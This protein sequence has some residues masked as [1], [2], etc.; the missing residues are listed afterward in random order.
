VLRHV[1]A[2]LAPQPGTILFERATVS[3]RGLPPQLFELWQQTD[4]PYRYR[5]IKWGHEGTGASQTVD[6]PATQLR[7]LARS[8]RANVDEVTF[9]G[10][11]AYKITVSGADDAFLNGTSYVSRDDYRPLEIDTT[12]GGGEII[13]YQDYRSLPAT[14]ANLGLLERGG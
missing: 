8:G 10:V 4:A 11:P 12:G 3:A 14:P 1:A 6:D 13:R 9:N 5:V 2:A 7:A